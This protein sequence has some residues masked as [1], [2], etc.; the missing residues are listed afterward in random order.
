MI[1]PQQAQKFTSVRSLGVVVGVV[2]VERRIGGNVSAYRSTTPL[3]T[4]QLLLSDLLW[5]LCRPICLS[6]GQGEKLRGGT[7][8]ERRSARDIVAPRREHFPTRPS[9][10]TAHRK[11]SD[12]S[13]TLRKPL[14]REFLFY[15][16]CQHLSMPMGSGFCVA[17][18][19][20]LPRIHVSKSNDELAPVSFAQ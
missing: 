10:S 4:G 6:G 20:R 14:S 2:R 16:N 8:F 17:R 11:S 5:F 7:S 13:A 9:F 19:P 15:L 18:E 3:Y 12:R 1:P